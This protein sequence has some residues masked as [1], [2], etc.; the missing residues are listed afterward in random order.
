MFYQ[1]IIY[2]Y[3]LKDRVDPHV[4]VYVE[5]RKG[6]PGLNQAR[7]LASN[8]LTKNLARNGYALVSH[9]SSR[10]RH[11]TSDLVFS[12][13]V[14]DFGINYT[15]KADSNHLRKFFREDYEITEDWTGEKYLGLTLKL[16]YSNRNESASMPGSV[17][18]ALLKFQ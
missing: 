13:V 14:N 18:A 12:L 5:I 10:W 4:Y 11:H 1:E 15:Q 3:N 2:Q 7:R 8:G 17:K 9:T 6:M 16:D